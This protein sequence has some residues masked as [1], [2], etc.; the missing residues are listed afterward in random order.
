M[1]EQDAK[2]HKPNNASHEFEYSRDT[3]MI[4][5]QSRQFKY[6]S[7]NGIL[8]KSHPKSGTFKHACGCETVHCSTLHMEGAE[9]EFIIVATACKNLKVLRLEEE[10]AHYEKILKSI[11]D[12]L[13]RL[14]T[15]PTIADLQQTVTEREAKM[16][17]LQE[18]MLLLRFK[19][20]ID[21]S[22][23]AELYQ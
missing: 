18:E 13:H 19:N 2:K 7:F 22:A 12:D 3:P 11:N 5:R 4:L 15:G 9:T 14:R 8:P 17:Q 10:K 16:Q 1:S 21:K 20:D 6:D 23:I